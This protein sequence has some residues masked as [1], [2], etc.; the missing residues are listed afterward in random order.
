MRLESVTRPMMRFESMMRPAMRLGTVRRVVGFESRRI[1]L[2]ILDQDC[3]LLIQWSTMWRR[4]G[5]FDDGWTDCLD[6]GPRDRRLWSNT[7]WWGFWNGWATGRTFFRNTLRFWYHWDS[8]LLDRCL[9]CDLLWGRRLLRRLLNGVDRSRTSCHSCESHWTMRYD[10]SD[11][12]I[13]EYANK[14]R[15]RGQVTACC[16]RVYERILLLWKRSIRMKSQTQVK[17]SYL[18]CSQ[19][20]PVPCKEHVYQIQK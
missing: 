17:Y 6:R 1:S 16:L 14:S 11:L 13:E 12:V 9:W 2:I 3:D 15:I 20:R 7:T 8:D 5:F 10:V 18:C 4:E 19:M